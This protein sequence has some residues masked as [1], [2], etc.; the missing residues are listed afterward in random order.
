MQLAASSRGLRRQ[1]P[2]ASND[3]FPSGSSELIWYD[4][5]RSMASSAI[6]PHLGQGAPVCPD[7]GTRTTLCSA[8]RLA[9]SVTPINKLQVPTFESTAMASPP[10]VNTREFYP[11]TPRAPAAGAARPRDG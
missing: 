5:L 3:H 10:M 11:P 7:G 6:E 8:A 9:H 1:N 4:T 2:V